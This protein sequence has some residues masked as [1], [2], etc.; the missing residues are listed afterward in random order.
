MRDFTQEEKEL[1]V[2]TPINRMN[3]FDMFEFTDLYIDMEFGSIKEQWLQ[4]VKMLEAL[5]IR[6]LKTKD[7][8][9]FIEFVRML[10]NSYKVVKL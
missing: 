2:N 4:I 8:E 7:E 9:L 5:R 1:I 3:C 10:P 6:C